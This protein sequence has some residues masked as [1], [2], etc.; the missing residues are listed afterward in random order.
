MPQ[1]SSARP[2][3]C[4]KSVGRQSGGGRARKKEVKVSF[5]SYT[6]ASI[7]TLQYIH[8]SRECPSPFIFLQKKDNIDIIQK[9]RYFTQQHYSL[10]FEPIHGF[11]LSLTHSTADGWRST[12][13]PRS[14][15]P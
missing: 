15:S 4:V 1:S 13:W 9:V 2:G 3:S 12:V 14:T 7:V 5:V 10:I 8:L 6:V 11:S